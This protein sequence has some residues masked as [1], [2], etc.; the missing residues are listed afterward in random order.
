MGQLCTPRP[1][2]CEGRYNFSSVIWRILH[3]YPIQVYIYSTLILIQ[4]INT[5]SRY[6]STVHTYL[7]NT[8]IPDPGIHLQYTHTYT[9]HIY[10]IQVYILQYTH[11]Y[12]IHLY[13]I[14]VYIYSSHILI[15]Y[16]YTSPYT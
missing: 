2:K 11:T 15:Q 3:T 10:P 12:T 4:Y 5:R 6:T 13:P 8:C 7:Y 9:I 1:L 16:I 14:Q